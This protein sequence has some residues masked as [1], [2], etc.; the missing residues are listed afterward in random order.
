MKEAMRFGRIL[1]NLFV[2][3]CPM[4]RKD[5]ISLQDLGI[6]AV[7]NLQTDEDIDDWEIDWGEIRQIY[8]LSQIKAFRYPI[9]DFDIN[10]LRA[11]FEEGVELLDELM[12]TNTVYLHCNAGLNRSPTLAIAFMVKKMNIDIDKAEHLFR[13]RY[14]A[15]PYTEA[16]RTLM[17][18]KG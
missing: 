12:R 10:D 6:T 14:H 8:E 5:V 11:K 1:K 4:S 3:S 16:L 13:E 7:L 15:E 18:K 2:G 9:R 17:L